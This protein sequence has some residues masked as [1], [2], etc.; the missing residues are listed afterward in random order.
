[1]SLTELLCDC[2]K[3]PTQKPDRIQFETLTSTFLLQS[4]IFDKCLWTAA[5]L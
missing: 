4:V 3:N 2:Y 1:M 5:D